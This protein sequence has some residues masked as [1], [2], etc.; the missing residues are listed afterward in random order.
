M[1]TYSCGLLAASVVG[2]LLHGH[3]GCVPGGLLGARFFLLLGGL[4]E[5]E[6]TVL[7]HVVLV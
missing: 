5:T 6:E 7:E 1:Y 2:G 3:G 4:E